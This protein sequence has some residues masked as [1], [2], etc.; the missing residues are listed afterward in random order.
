MPT[1]SYCQHSVCEYATE[2]LLTPFYISNQNEGL[3][4]KNGVGVF[5]CLSDYGIDADDLILPA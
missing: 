3:F 4:C 5:K 1:I 2:E